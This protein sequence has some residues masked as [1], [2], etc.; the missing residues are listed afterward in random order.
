MVDDDDVVAAAAAA[1]VVV[2][3][4]VTTPPMAI[5]PAV[6]ILF[7]PLWMISGLTPA[8]DKHM[9]DMICVS[10][11]LRRLFISRQMVEGKKIG[12]CCYGAY[13]IIVRFVSPEVGLKSYFTFSLRH[14]P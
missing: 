14:D 2:V 13:P 12:N 10:A 11:V 8:Y 9:T 7:T 4:V 6:F 1:V 5:R 3:V